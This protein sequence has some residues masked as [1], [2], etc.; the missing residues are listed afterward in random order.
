MSDFFRNPNQS[1][2]FCMVVPVPFLFYLQNNT[3]GLIIIQGKNIFLPWYYCAR[4]EKKLGNKWFSIF[5]TEGDQYYLK[6]S[7]WVGVE[8]NLSLSDQI[9]IWILLEIIHFF[10]FLHKPCSFLRRDGEEDWLRE[11]GKRQNLKKDFYSIFGSW[12]STISYIM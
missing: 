4:H 3:H 2:Y 10:R 1:L 9:H 6:L 12:R 8:T 11:G 7:L 5:H